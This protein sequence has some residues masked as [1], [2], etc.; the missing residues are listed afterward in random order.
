M[1]NRYPILLIIFFYALNSKAQN[2]HYIKQ[3]ISTL[4]G[5]GFGGRGYVSNSRD[6]AARFIYRNFS[7][8]GLK[9]FSDNGDYFQLYQFPV[10]I[11]PNKVELKLGKKQ[12]IPGVDFLVDAAS[13]GYRTN[14]TTKI[15]RINL[16]KVDDSA[17]WQKVKARFNA[18]NVYQLSHAD[19]LCK[20]LKIRMSNLVEQLPKA[21]YVIPQS[22]KLIWTVATDTIPATVFYVADTSLPKG[23]KVEV[24][25]QHKFD[26]KAI[27]KNVIAYIPG[28]EASDSFFVFTAHYDHLGKMGMNAVFPGANDNASG[29]AFNLTLAK[30]FVAHPQKYSIVFIAFSGEEAGLLGS[31]YFV[32]HPVFPLKKIKF[33]VN[34]DLM[35]DA[36]DGITVVNAVQQNS[37]FKLL[38]KI[39]SEKKYLPKILSRDNAPNSDHYPFTQADVPAIFIYANGGKGYYHDVFDKAKELSLNNIPQVFQLLTDF[40]ALKSKG[41]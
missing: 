21:C 10:N 1:K 2:V 9:S 30:Y 19:S 39:N 3:S 8:M 34:I 41:E 38:Q 20:R 22:N 23:R 36:T 40:I 32:E 16:N 13:V 18:F 5:H 31:R 25:V 17:E 27:S 6:K 37:S 35:G 28:S 4:S 11:F 15:E 12:L 14:G 7:E 26:P 29:T 33:L 24:N